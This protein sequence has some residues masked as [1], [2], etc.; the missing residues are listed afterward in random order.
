MT[1]VESQVP[2]LAGRHVIVCYA[3]GSVDV[4]DCTVAKAME[5]F[6]SHKDSIPREVLELANLDRKAHMP[7][8]VDLLLRLLKDAAGGIAVGDQFP[9][10]R[11]L[12]HGLAPKPPAED[13]RP[14]VFLT[15]D[16][17][18]QVALFAGRS[19]LVID[20]LY[21]G[22]IREHNILEKIPFLKELA[23]TS[24]IPWYLVDYADYFD[25]ASR[26]NAIVHGRWKEGATEVG[27]ATS[28]IRFTKEFLVGRE[29]TALEVVKIQ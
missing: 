22:S 19:G 23:A 7:V 4:H 1:N 18:D 14:E 8:S 21:A 6:N 2:A 12:R 28:I 20:K 25:Y 3:Y 17:A 13:T 27:K 29:F 10:L 15:Q 24:P 16:M 11:Q 5:Y 26:Y 9:R